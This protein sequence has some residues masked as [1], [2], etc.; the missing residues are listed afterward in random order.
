M[1]ACLQSLLCAVFKKITEGVVE[2]LTHCP[3]VRLLVDGHVMFNSNQW[4]VV[5]SLVWSSFP[6][7]CCMPALLVI[8]WFNQILPKPIKFQCIR[9]VISVKT[10]D[11]VDKG[12]LMFK[13]KNHL[14]LD[15]RKTMKNL[16]HLYK[17]HSWALIA[18]QVFQLF[19]SI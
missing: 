10:W 4:L 17:S 11:G 5:W 7:S 16:E 14:E 1:I 15:V 2:A 3:S 9:R 13:K 8:I 6:T 12:W 18:F 19:P